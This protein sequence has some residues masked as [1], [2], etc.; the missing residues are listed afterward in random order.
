MLAMG[1]NTFWRSFIMKTRWLLV[2]AAV[3]I[4]GA[5]GKDDTKGDMKKIQGTW[6][7]AALERDGQ[8]IDLSTEEH[9]PAKAVFEGETVTITMKDGKTHKGTIKLDATQSPKAID[10]IPGGGPNKG[11]VMKGIYSLKDDTLAICHGSSGDERPKAVG[12][13]KGSKAMMVVFKRSKE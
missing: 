5:E 1:S 9:V 13:K 8:K 11:K 7:V 4:L 3:V 12:T 2:A 10:L 6:T